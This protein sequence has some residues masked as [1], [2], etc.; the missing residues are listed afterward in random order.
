LRTNDRDGK[1]ILMSRDRTRLTTADLFSTASTRKQ[2][3]SLSANPS[4]SSSAITDAPA[5]DFSVR[6]VLPR[7]LANAVKRL[8]DQE[9]DRLLAAVL[10][11]Q[12]RRGRKLPVSN[13]S[14]RKRRVEAVDV[15]LTLGK[16]NAVRAA[17][18]AGVKPTQIARQ[19]GLSL[20]DVRKALAS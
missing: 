14:L 13:E 5:K 7:D 10:A 16:L 1:V 11:E 8:E 4:P 6:H 15:H 19:F 17:F 3:S 9:F 18:Q 12:Q 2:P 20:S